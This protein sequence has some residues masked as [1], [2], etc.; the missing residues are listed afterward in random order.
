VSANEVPNRVWCKCCTCPT[1]KRSIRSWRMLRIGFRGLIEKGT[2][3]AEIVDT[4]FVVALSRRPSDEES[5]EFAERDFRIRRR[6]QTSDR[7][8]LLERSDQHRVRLQSLIN[9]FSKASRIKI[10]EDTLPRRVGGSAFRGR[11]G[12]CSISRFTSNNLYKAKSTNPII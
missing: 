11:G 4:L 8:R 7:R 1:A 9:V 6:P 2:N 10:G 3:D 12:S 5:Q